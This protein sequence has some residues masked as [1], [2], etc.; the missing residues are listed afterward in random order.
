VGQGGI[1]KSRL[2]WEFEKYV[3]GVVDTVYWHNGRS[4]AYGEGISYWA[5]AEMVRGR[6]GIAESDEPQLALS[7]LREALSEWI[8]D[9]QERS[10]VEPR[11]AA[12]LALEPMPQGSRDELFAA[13]RTFFERIA[14]R[15]PTVLVFEDIQWADDGMLDFITELLDRARNAPVFVV[16]LARPELHERRPGWGASLRSVTAMNLD[17]L[18]PEHMAAMVRGTVPGIPADAVSA[19]AERADGIPLYAVEMIRMLIDR[20]DLMLAGDGH[21]TMARRLERLAVPETLHALIAARLDG[22][23]EHDRKLLQTGAVLGQSFTL[24][25]LSAVAGEEAEALRDRLAPVV[26]RQLLRVD[27]DPRSPERGQYQFVQAVAELA[28]ATQEVP[29]CIGEGAASPF[30]SA[31]LGLDQPHSQ[32]LLGLFEPL[33][34]RPVGNLH[35]LDRPG[36]RARSI[37]AL[38][39][40]QAP[41]ADHHLAVPLYPEFGAR[42]QT[43]DTQGCRAVHRSLLLCRCR[44]FWISHES[45]CWAE[46][47]QSTPSCIESHNAGGKSTPSRRAVARPD[48]QPP[49]HEG[50]KV[51]PRK[52]VAPSRICG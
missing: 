40:H 38:Q 4:P 10:W 20:G 13:W 31:R 41:V 51:R 43:R 16:A 46:A 29:R 2:A 18:E 52:V 33:P 49:S 32:P 14:E 7:R 35:L 36:Q 11:L 42:L 48:N 19:I 8:P 6:A 39:Q 15:A 50:T 5:L 17:P 45:S 37:D 47:G 44:G 21:Y 24:E 28:I 25:A 26:R 12:L 22:L 9:D 23:G 1:G 34:G 27:V 30:G 3:D